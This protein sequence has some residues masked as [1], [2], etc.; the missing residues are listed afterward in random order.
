MAVDLI[1]LGVE[2]NR[3][4][5]CKPGALAEA[6]SIKA[7]TA[8]DCINAA[9]I[10]DAVIAIATIKL[11]AIGPC[12]HRII[13]G[14]RNECIGASTRQDG[15][16]PAPTLDIIIAKARANIIILLTAID[17]ANLIPG[18]DRIRVI[19]CPVN[20]G[21][22]LKMLDRI[23][24]RASIICNQCDVAGRGAEINNIGAA[25]ADIAVQTGRAD[26]R[27]IR[28]AA[29]EKIVI[30]IAAKIIGESSCAC[31]ILNVA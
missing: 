28:T 7:I 11:A 23:G 20:N 18:D 8:G 10:D 31:H 16:I 29:D 22:I 3:R 25:T 27:I 19:D 9:A 2:I 14:P 26:E 15:I 24:S 1:Y 6:Y 21:N 12:A 17:L 13:A 5:L 4:A 30:I